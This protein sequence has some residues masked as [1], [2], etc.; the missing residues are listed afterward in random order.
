MF[1]YRGEQPFT[2]TTIDILLIG[3]S[4]SLITTDMAIIA[5]SKGTEN[6]AKVKHIAR[7]AFITSWSCRVL[8]MIDQNLTFLA[9]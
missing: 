7:K 1:L 4:L 6:V 3:M 2:P 9:A 5:V 8:A